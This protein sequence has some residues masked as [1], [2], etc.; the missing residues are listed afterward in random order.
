M[1]SQHGLPARAGQFAVFGTLPAIGWQ[2]ERALSVA[3]AASQ[4]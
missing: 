3:A 2:A 1:R 4:R